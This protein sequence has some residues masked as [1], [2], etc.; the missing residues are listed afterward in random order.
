MTKQKFKVEFTESQKYIVDVLARD[1]QEAKQLAEAKWYDIVSNGTAHY[2]E[3]SDLE[4]SLTAVY[5]V[6]GT[7]DPFNT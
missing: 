3:D 6:S 1:E 2:Y 5:D 7:D 4:T